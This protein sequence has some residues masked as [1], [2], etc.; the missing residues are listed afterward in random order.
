MK[1]FFGG[2]I[3]VLCAMFVISC[4][5]SDSS[6]G[7]DKEGDKG[8]SKC[9]NGKIDDG[10]ACD[11]NVACWEVGHF[12]PETQAICN[13]DCTAFSE[14]SAYD[15]SKCIPRDPSDNCG[16]FQ[17]DSGEQCEQGNT[18]PCTELPGNYTVGDAICRRDCRGWDP[19]PCSTGGK[20]NTCA[21]VVDCYNKCADDSCKEKCK[22]T[23]TDQGMVSFDALEKCAAACG[24]LND[25]ACLT[26]NCYDAYYACFPTKKCG[27]GKIDD[28]EICEAKETKP[29]QELNTA[30]KEWQPINDAVCNSS[31]D[32]WDTY[33]CV[34]INALTCFQVYECA[35]DCTDSEC[36]AAC[37]A[38]T[39]PAA[40]QKYDA[41][42]EC[43]NANCP[44]ATEEC[45]ID[46]CKFQSDACKTHLTCGNGNIDQYEVCEKSDFV[47]CGELKN[48]A[49]EPIY[50]VGTASAFC[51]PNCTEY[52]VL[53]CHKFCSCAEIQTCIDKECGGYPTSNAE[54]TDEKQACMKKC[55]EEGSEEGAGEHKNYV[56]T[57]MACSE[58]NS[59]QSGWDLSEDMRSQCASQFGADCS[60]GDNPK[61]PY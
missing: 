43:L 2:L 22:E 58:Q 51:G 16:N 17:I 54:Y 29:C 44:V 3:L 11:G 21:Q 56:S 24:G 23:G 10:E 47:D 61:C 28:G 57:I 42:M 37:I 27:N 45:M 33:S 31:C 46:K 7:G 15:T 55:E 6:N 4:G 1:K 30:D 20:I 53:M 19:T 49:G 60:A 9:G 40:K 36:E 26:Q 52:S 25:A 34:D 38:K 32:G 50:E 18:K 35:K 5:D 14:E 13:K 12:Y 48:E 41:M 8:G 39:W 59:G